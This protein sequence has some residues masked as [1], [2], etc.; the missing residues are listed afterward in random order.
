VPDDAVER[1]YLRAQELA[2]WLVQV[3][4]EAPPTT[5]TSHQP[6]VGAAVRLLGTGVAVVL[7]IDGDKLWLSMLSRASKPVAK[8]MASAARP[9]HP[10]AV[11]ELLLVPVP[12]ELFV[13]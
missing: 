7:G 13:T 2:T 11:G 3:E 10:P 9:V 6:L 1:S 5:S 8:F 12:R 4:R